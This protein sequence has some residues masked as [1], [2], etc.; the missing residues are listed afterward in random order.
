MST[1]ALVGLLFAAMLHAYWNFLLKRSQNR[2]AHPALAMLIASIVLVVPALSALQSIPLEGWGLIAISAVFQATYM[3]ALGA[4][5]QGGQLSVSYP[6][7]RGSTPL[8]TVLGA[9]LFVSERI[10]LL[11]GIGIALTVL[12][13]YVLHLPALNQGWLTPINALANRP[14]QAA[15]LSGALAAG[16]SNVDKLGVAQVSPP[17]YMCLAF[18][19]AAALL[20]PY[21][22]VNQRAAVLAE[23]R[24]NWRGVLLTGLLLVI[25]YQI[26]LFALTVTK[27][28][29]ATAVRGASVVF[30]ALLGMV[31][32]K[33]GLS[34]TRVLGALVIFIGIACIGL[35]E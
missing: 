21:L 31:A 26:I 33:E 17:L 4:A 5:Y 28:S 12:G 3:L 23:W 30:G 22:L 10:S 25:G 24:E 32:L 1:I 9:V 15:L 34:P 7:S 11:G 27:V 2:V 6:I 13:I 18:G 19:L 35:A 8:F 20:L 29:Y 14:A 16:Y